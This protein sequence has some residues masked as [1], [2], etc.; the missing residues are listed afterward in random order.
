MI[1]YDFRIDSGILVMRPEG[2]LEAADFNLMSNRIDPYLVGHG[3]LH[4]VLILAKSFPGWK[5]FAAMLA[6]FKFLKDHIK[7][8]EKVAVAADGVLADVMPGIANHFVHAE[9]RHFESMREDEALEWL[10]QA[11]KAG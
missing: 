9:V 2:P 3:K 5:D 6:H 4:G 7:N 8:I 11:G 10:S 1:T